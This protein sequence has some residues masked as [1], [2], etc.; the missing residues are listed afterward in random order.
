[1]RISLSFLSAGP[2]REYLARPLKLPSFP[3]SEIVDGI[4]SLYY[5]SAFESDMHVYSASTI[6]DDLRSYC[7]TRYKITE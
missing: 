6:Y 1:M 4:P 2:T 7:D 3:R 5:G